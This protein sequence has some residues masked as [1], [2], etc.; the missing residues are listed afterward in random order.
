[1]CTLILVLSLQDAFL[2]NMFYFIK[3]S[4]SQGLLSC[5]CSLYLNKTLLLYE[6]YN[7]LSSCTHHVIMDVE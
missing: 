7:A 3:L 2:R 5:D 1:M 4:S 6:F